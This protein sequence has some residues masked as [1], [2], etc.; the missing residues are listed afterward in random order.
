MG[1]EPCKRWQ[2]GL[3][4]VGGAVGSGT[5]LESIRPP[6]LL[7]HHSRREEGPHTQL[8]GLGG[9]RS[10]GK[11]HGEV[12]GVLAGTY[13]FCSEPRL[14]WQTVN[15]RQSLQPRGDTRE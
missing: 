13:H 12:D 6:G 1:K 9:Q 5:A 3:Q 4:Q 10:P 8:K 7:P 11:G 14:S 2:C 15:S